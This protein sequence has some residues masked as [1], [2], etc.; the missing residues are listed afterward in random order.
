M[1]KNFPS[2]TLVRHDPEA[3]SRSRGLAE[4]IHPYDGFGGRPGGWRLEIRPKAS[5][6]TTVQ[7]RSPNKRSRWTDSRTLATKAVGGLSEP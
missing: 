7:V 1:G 2:A 4:L 3:Q 6:V 5:A